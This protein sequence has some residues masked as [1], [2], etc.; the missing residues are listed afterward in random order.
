[1]HVIHVQP[2]TWRTR[3]YLL[4]LDLPRNLSGV[5][6]LTSSYAAAGLAL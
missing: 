5:G 4:I 2:P 6:G 1:M 3:V